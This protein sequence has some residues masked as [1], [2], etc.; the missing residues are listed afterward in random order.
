MP[1]FI[2]HNIFGAFNVT[3]IY[4]SSHLFI[5]DFDRFGP[6]YTTFSLSE[7]K[8]GRRWM[9][10]IVPLQSDESSALCVRADNEGEEEEAVVADTPAAAVI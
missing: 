8:K 4:I 5:F 10:T 1:T 7:G 6:P 2:F 3:L 9:I